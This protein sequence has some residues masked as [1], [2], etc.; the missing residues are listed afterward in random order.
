MTMPTLDLPGL[1]RREEQKMIPPWQDICI[2]LTVYIL[3][4]Y[5]DGGHEAAGYETMQEGYFRV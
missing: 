1:N 4:H 3:E 2:S 5:E